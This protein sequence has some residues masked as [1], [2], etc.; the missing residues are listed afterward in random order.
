ML[1]SGLG[2][3]C[4]AF[5]EETRKRKAVVDGVLARARKQLSK[6]ILEYRE[7]T[8]SGSGAEDS[9]LDDVRN[10][11]NEHVGQCDADEATVRLLQAIQRLAA[12]RKAP[13]TTLAS[14]ETMG[15]E[16]SVLDALGQQLEEIEAEL[17]AD[18]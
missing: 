18:S 13:L 4:P 9:F 5:R 8:N 10:E 1:D 11:T 16:P 15:V 7:G 2:P 6:F 14:L 12:D 3:H 17:A